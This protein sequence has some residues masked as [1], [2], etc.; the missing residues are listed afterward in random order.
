M[1]QIPLSDNPL[2]RVCQLFCHG[3]QMW[4]LGAGASLEANLPLVSGLTER[5]RKELSDVKLDQQP[6]LRIGHVIEGLLQEIGDS[7]TIETV[8]D[9]LADHVSIARRNQKSEVPISIKAADGSVERQQLCTG[10]L[11]EIQ[12][13]ILRQIRDTLCWGYVHADEP[14]NIEIGTT[15]EPIVKIQNH[16]KFVDVLFSLLRAGREHRVHPIDFFTTNYDTLIEDALALQSIPYVDG[17]V[18]GAVAYWNPLTLNSRDLHGTKIGARVLKLHGSIDWA[19]VNDHIVRTRILDAYPTAQRDL[20]IYPQAMK[21]DL[22][23]REPFDSMF[24]QFRVALNRIEPQVLC[25]CGFG[26]GDTHINQELYNSLRKEGSQLTV[27]VFSEKRDQ[28]PTTWQEEQIGERVYILTRDGLWRGSSQLAD[29][30]HEG[31]K[32]WWTFSGMI[33]FLKTWTN[34]PV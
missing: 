19:Q 30:G 9:H 4:L 18:G 21:Y 1:A 7:A 27:V 29:N 13:N 32:T 6:S 8:L 10:I 26:F 17:F 16:T 14:Q 23:K 31:W 5:I 15:D 12:R 25:I 34:A 24:Q 22:T 11:E 3:R 20:L 28:I 33:R 2:A